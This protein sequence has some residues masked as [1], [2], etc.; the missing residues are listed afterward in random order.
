MKAPLL[1]G[2]LL[3]VEDSSQAIAPGARLSQAIFNDFAAIG[4]GGGELALP[5][6]DL[7]VKAV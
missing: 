5:S 4:R 7:L 1:R 2:V 3:T 6:C